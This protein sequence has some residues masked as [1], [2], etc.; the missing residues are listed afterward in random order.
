[1]IAFQCCFCIICV[2]PM[3]G[4]AFLSC[5]CYALLLLML[6]VVVMLPIG[7]CC[8]DVDCCGLLCVVDLYVACVCYVIRRCYCCLFVLL[9]A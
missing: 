2:V 6:C 4:V 8:V 3:L 9:R 7:R 5:L 1:M